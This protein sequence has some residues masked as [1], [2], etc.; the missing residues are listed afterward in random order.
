ME[1]LTSLSSSCF[2]ELP[3]LVKLLTNF[4]KMSCRMSEI[5]WKPQSYAMTVLVLSS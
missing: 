4:S 3:S 5:D 2:F 1:V